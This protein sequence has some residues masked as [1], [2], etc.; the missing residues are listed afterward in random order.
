[1]LPIRVMIN[2]GIK[3]LFVTNAAG[4]INQSF[5]VGDLMVIRDHIGLP[6]MNSINPLVGENDERLVMCCISF[7][8]F[9]PLSTIGF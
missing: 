7:L 5:D 6:L 2:L 1:M 9:A 3:H 4:G 8:P